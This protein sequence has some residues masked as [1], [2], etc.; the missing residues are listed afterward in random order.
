MVNNQQKID[1]LLMKQ[2]ETE[3]YLAHMGMQR[4]ELVENYMKSQKLAICLG[5]DNKKRG[6]AKAFNEMNDHMHAEKKN[7]FE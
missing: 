4:D 6:M 5:R 3:E 7:H 1:D 2:E